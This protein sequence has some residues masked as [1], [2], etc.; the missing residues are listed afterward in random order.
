MKT[1]SIQHALLPLLLLLSGSSYWF[2][3]A[4]STTLQA[5]KDQQPY[6]YPMLQKGKSKIGFVQPTAPK[7]AKPTKKDEKE[8]QEEENLLPDV[9]LLKFILDKSKEGLPVLQLPAFLYR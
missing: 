7:K 4:R 3:Q 2:L 8:F 9:Q 1:F 6:S 5:Y